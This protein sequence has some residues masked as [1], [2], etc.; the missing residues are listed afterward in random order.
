MSI[1][2]FQYQSQ[3]YLTTVSWELLENRLE[4]NRWLKVNVTLVCHIS[5]RNSTFHMQKTECALRSRLDET[6]PATS[7]KW[8]VRRA[9]WLKQTYC[10]SNL[11]IMGHSREEL[12]THYVLPLKLSFTTEVLTIKI[13]SVDYAVPRK[14]LIANTKYCQLKILERCLSRD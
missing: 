14:S 11:S 1:I 2:H 13:L 12:L 8:K 4:T 5:V 9:E 6:R 7:S 3:N 10:C